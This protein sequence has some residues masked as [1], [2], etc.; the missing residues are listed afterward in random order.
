MDSPE[1]RMQIRRDAVRL[2]MGLGRGGNAA[3]LGQ[4]DPKLDTRAEME[5]ARAQLSATIERLRQSIDASLAQSKKDY[6]KIIGKAKKDAKKD[7]KEPSKE[8]EKNLMDPDDEP[9]KNGRRR[10]T[11]EQIREAIRNRFSAPESSLQDNES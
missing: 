10:L 4:D 6:L 3:W 5:Q 7:E 9:E 1:F 8:R 2:A 11:P